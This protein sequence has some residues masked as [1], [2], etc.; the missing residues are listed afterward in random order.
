MKWCDSGRPSYVDSKAKQL[1]G[2]TNGSS[3][4]IGN[5]NGDEGQEE[6]D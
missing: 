4:L 3:G 1:Q 2:D 5:T 6:D